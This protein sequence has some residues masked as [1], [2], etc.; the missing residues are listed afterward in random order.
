MSSV[1]VDLEDLK[2]LVFYTGVI[3]TIEGVL[4]SHRADPFVPPVLEI[5]AAHD[6]LAAAMR[7]AERST[8][9]TLIAWD[10][11]LDAEE[12]RLLRVIDEDGTMTLTRDEKAPEPGEP[13]SV[14]DRLAAKGCVII[15]QLVKGILW[16]G[17][18]QPTLV[19]DPSGFPVKITGRGRE[20]LAKINLNVKYKKTDG[21]M[22]DALINEDR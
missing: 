12:T 10:G 5:T 1:T 15:G 18:K 17:D 4:A 8:A 16:A 14:A 22:K 3:K 21:A 20:K 6:R 2:A 13:M 7:N 11:E 19:P 9:D